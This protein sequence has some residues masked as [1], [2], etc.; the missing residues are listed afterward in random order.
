MSSRL[1]LDSNVLVLLI[2]GYTDRR[3]IPK[4]KNLSSFTVGDFDVLLDVIA[5]YN[6]VLA[7]PHVLAEASNL[8]AQH[9][10]PERS[11]L[12]TTLQH[13]AAD[14]QKEAAVPSDACAARPEFSRL[15]LT[16]CGLLAAADTDSVVLTTD[17]D[18]YLAL[19]RQRPDAAIN[20]T[21]LIYR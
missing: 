18:L 8:L 4:H 12:L 20:F 15:G 14:P 3:V 16:D 10:D 5:G 6:E 19:S 17:L 11:L 21:H 9:A 1:L 2:A 7:T 13:M